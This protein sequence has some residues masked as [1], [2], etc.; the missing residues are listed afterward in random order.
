MARIKYDFTHI[1]YMTLFENITKITSK[2]CISDENQI[3]FIINK[4]NIAK[5][6]GKGGS[7]VRLLER[8]LGKKLR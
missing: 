4:E 1:K 3:T 8:K 7:N 2:D 5:A 6:I